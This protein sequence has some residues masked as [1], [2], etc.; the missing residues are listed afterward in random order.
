MSTGVFAETRKSTLVQT[1]VEYAIINNMKKETML[2]FFEEVETEQE[3]NG[4]YY[5]VAE[6]VTIVVL[7]SIC[8]LKNVSQI[9]Q[10]AEYDR[11]REFLRENFA[12]ERIPC[13]Y[14]L[15]SLLKMVKPESLNR[16]LANWVASQIP[17]QREGLTLSLD[18][19]TVRST[20]K[21]KKHRNPIHIVSAQLSELGLTFA[22]KSAAGKGS[23]IPAVQELLREMDIVG[24]MVVADALNC[25]KETAKVIVDG[26]GDYLLSV[27]AN[28]RTLMED[29]EEYVQDEQIRT[30]MSSQ[31]QTEKN[32]GR[33]ETRTAFVTTDVSWLSQRKDWNNLCCIGAI[34]TEFETDKGKTSEWHYYI[35][36]RKLTPLELLHH[37][38]MEWAVETMHWLLDV[39]YGE[40]YLRV[41]NKSIQENM[42]LLRKFALG[43]IKQYKTKTGSK[44][45]LSKLM[46]GCLLDSSLTLRI[47]F[48][49]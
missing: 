13:Y 47:I 28:Q 9:H 46:L 3:Y 18:G 43:L 34:H 7:G 22:S 44:L 45:P 14:W 30:T 25:Q 10:W 4:Y 6:A 17:E 24:C 35:S 27:K 2:D 16:C 15:L 1:F 39:H 49:N 37:A 29:I 11:T 12:I 40:D 21:M 5:S 31:K 26:N 42:N 41:A 32:R 20:E 23:E 36:S 19:K 48:Q 8:G 33:I 38:R